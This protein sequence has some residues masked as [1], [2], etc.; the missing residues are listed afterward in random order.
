M[1]MQKR[2]AVLQTAELRIVLYLAG[3]KS[4]R[5]FLSFICCVV[6]FSLVKGQSHFLEPAD[7]LHKGRFWAC[8]GIGAGLYGSAS[9][10]L[11][12]AWYKN[13]ALRGF[14]TFDD[15]GQWLD[16]DKAGHLLT[17]YAQAD[18][19]YQ[20]L[21]WTGMEHRKSVWLAAGVGT[22]LQGTVELMDAHSAKWGFSWYDIGFNTLGVGLF[23]AQELA[24]QEQRVR[25]KI[26]HTPV[27]YPDYLVPASGEGPG[28]PLRQRAEELYGRSYAET[29]LKDYNGQVVWASVN[30]RSWLA[31]D[32]ATWL[33]PWL[34]I[35]VGYSGANMFGGYGNS[36]RSAQGQAYVL[37]AAAFPRH[38]QWYL[39]LDVDLKRIPAQKRWLRTV[40]SLLNW[41]KIPAPAIEFNTQGQG[42]RFT[43][44]MW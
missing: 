30:L 22:V 8:A 2:I 5:F 10:G 44:L 36:W 27:D 7:S 17:A 25:F 13:Q 21:R 33:P 3:M 18:V 19:A 16:M 15:S 42:V 9:Y 29:F 12:H 14:H 37:D 43:P 41:V 6:V 39:S 31:R 40:F 4:V 23:A 1:C 24:W 20:G 28:Y 34:N 32:G 11:Y 35:A 26:S 38:R